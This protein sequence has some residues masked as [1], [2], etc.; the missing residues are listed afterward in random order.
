M[1]GDGPDELLV[2]YEG[3]GTN[4]RR[5][6]ATDERS[7]I[8]AVTDS[9]GALLAINRYDEF[10]IPQS[11]NLGRFQ[12]T[13]QAWLP[14]LGMYQYKARIYSAT[15][16]RF[17]QTDPI[18]YAGG[19]NLYAYVTN[20]PVN[21]TDPLGLNQ[22]CFP[23]I[24]REAYATVDQN[25]DPVIVG[26]EYGQECT[27]I[28]DFDLG[29]FVPDEVVVVGRRIRDRARDVTR[30]IRSAFCAVPSF[31]FG[32]EGATFLGAG[33]RYG[34]GLAY[35]TASGELTW[36]GI[37]AGGAGLGGGGSF[38]FSLS[39]QT[40]MPGTYG[41]L[42]S[43]VALGYGLYGFDFTY[44][45]ATVTGGRNLGSQGASTNIGLAKGFGVGYVSVLET[46][47]TKVGHVAN[48][49]TIC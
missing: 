14:E 43:R 41:N 48:L 31:E 35:N 21:F 24:I 49:G 28:P 1:R 4:D 42:D 2:W 32:G 7:S 5:F 9:S 11:G 29:N 6:L 25:N 12:Y 18:G 16:G 26:A 37:F 17:L 8:S 45:W 33:V 46:N 30:K 47:I 40:A 13:G 20:D 22:F 38:G 36:K 19:I 15:L 34:G 3:A 44:N 10:G 23:I 27:N 39:T